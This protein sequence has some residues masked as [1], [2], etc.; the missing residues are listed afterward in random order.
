VTLLLSIFAN[1]ILPAFLVVGVGALL[2]VTVRP[3]VK[4]ISR[5]TFYAITPCLIFSGLVRTQLT[6]SEVQQV[7]LFAALATLSTA[8]LAWL[9]GF[10]LRWDSRR[11]RAL[12]L[13]V[14]SVNAGNM[15]LS[16]VLLAFGE[17]AQARALIYFVASAVIGN[18]LGV[19]IAAG[20][21][22]WRQ[23]LGNVA[24]VP[25]IYATAAALLL[26]A[27]PQVHVPELLMQPIEL[28]GRAAVPLMLLVLG[29]Q[30]GRSA[31]TV[32]SHAA[33]ISL[34]TVLRLLVAPVFAFVIARITRVQGVTWQASI[35]EAS[36][37]AGVTS[38]I[39][40]LE[41]DLEPEA[42]TGTVFISTLCSA[43][44]LSV[45]ISILS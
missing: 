36:M 18:S 39:V 24:R 34:A 10:L 8:A 16:V 31:G 23:V 38:T 1:N 15:G 40:A 17:Q 5:T 45:L 32:R 19:A 6:G 33:S 20:G 4:A 21:G 35:L 26:N 7:A 28:L 9:V 2:S 11:I 14:M 27:F 42:V 13:P 44:T 3:D 12:I 22:S 41:Y 29:L 37:P 43:F 25:M 30:L